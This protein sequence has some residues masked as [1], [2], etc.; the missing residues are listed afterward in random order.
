MKKFG[1]FIAVIALLGLL[2]ACNGSDKKTNETKTEQ[3]TPVE[4]AEATKGDLVI[5]KDVYGKAVPN[6][7]TPIMLQNLGEVDSL[8]VAEGDRVE[9][10]D[11]LAVIKTPV[12]KQTIK[13]PA[14]GTVANLK[15]GEGEMVSNEEPF[16]VIA[17]TE[18]IKL[19]FAVTDRLQTHFKKADKRNVFI[20]N[21]KYAAE[22]T[23]IGTLPNETGLYPIEATV[24]NKEYDILPGTVVKMEVPVKRVKK[25]IIVP[26]SAIVEEADSTFIYI[27][28]DDK[29]KQ[30]KVE[31][32]DSQSD[33]TAIKG[34]VKAGSQIVVNGQMTL[35]NGSKVN[36]VK[37][38][39]E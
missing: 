25:T 21:K 6:K 12:G 8:K 15:A 2:A 29:A 28:E 4:I 38:S 34:D 1:V 14:K 22:L 19:Q 16:A 36:V 31:I 13:A 23:A 9:K 27:V 39:G 10:D 3:V 26:T 17:D 18:K 24:L 32:S 5:E 37:E 30:V 33:L 35:E 11:E 20:G 7:T